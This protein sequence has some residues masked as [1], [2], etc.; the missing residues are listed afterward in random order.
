MCWWKVHHEQNLHCLV[1]SGDINMNELYHLNGQYVF[2]QVCP[3]G[4]CWVKR[5]RHKAPDDQNWSYFKLDCYKACARLRESISRTKGPSP[6]VGNMTELHPIF[7][8][9]STEV[10]DVVMS[11]MLI[12]PLVLHPSPAPC[13]DYRPRA[14]NEKMCQLYCVLKIIIAEISLNH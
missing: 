12:L 2:N 3:T 14:T 8:L 10:A 5:Y 7:T 6:H 1:V 11:R 4:T 13:V 9:A